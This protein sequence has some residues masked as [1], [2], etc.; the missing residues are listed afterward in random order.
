VILILRPTRRS[1]QGFFEAVLE[2]SQRLRLLEN[3]D[4][5][6]HA[7][8]KEKEMADFRRC[9]LVLAALALLLGTVG[10]VSAQQQQAY[11]C[12]STATPL[13]VRYEGLAELVGDFVLQCTGG[14]PTDPGAPAQKVNIQI[15]LNTPTV[16]SRVLTSPGTEALLLVD[17]P[18]PT[19]QTLCAVGANCPV[20]G[21][22][23][24]TSSPYKPT[25]ATNT[26][27]N[28][29]PIFNVWQGQLAGAASPNSIVFNGVP[30]IAPGTQGGTRTFRITNVRAPANALGVPAPGIP[31]SITESIATSNGSI[32]P[33]SS[34]TAQQV[35][36]VVLKGLIVTNSGGTV[37]QQCFSVTNGTSGSITLTKGFAAAFKVRNT[38]TT[39]AAP[40]GDAPQNVPNTAYNTETGFYNQTLLANA[41]NATQGTRFRIVFTNVNKGVTLSVPTSLQYDPNTGL[42]VLNQP[43]PVTVPPAVPP[44]Y[45]V[46]TTTD[47]NGGGGFVAGTGAITPDSSGTATAVYEVLQADISN[48]NE[49]LTIPVTI[50]FV[51]NPGSNIPAITVGTPSQ[52]GASFAP[53]SN[54]SVAS[55]FSVPIPRFRDTS[56][57]GAH[58]SIGKCA[59]HLLFPFVTNQAGFDTGMAISNTSADPYLTSTQAGT[60]TL[61]FF[62][63]SAPAAVTTANVAAGTTY[64]TTALAV[65]PGFQGYVIADCQF[66]FAHGF[67]FVTRVGAVDVAMGYLALVIPDNIQ[68]TGRIPNPVSCPP[69]AILPCGQGSGEQLA[70]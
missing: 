70:E 21:L 40:L 9:I 54:I 24:S 1:P 30:I 34:N 4:R 28:P 56:S 51:S 8:Y 55:D 58:F 3:F 25:T 48:P 49:Q 27:P 20:L 5:F 43:A 42:T 44:L 29:L 68:T 19:E 65:A 7:L 52:L 33:I 10:T 67:A 15:F 61:N 17:E 47:A 50:S 18:A 32:L 38:A 16:T 14:N 59:S 57:G 69:G 45:A 39:P 11:T 60:C 22:G 12:F 62:G 31:L 41:G 6:N 23:S 53:I 35:V 46:L 66:Q 2:S 63:A 26:N 13:Q 36:G 37:F 64:T